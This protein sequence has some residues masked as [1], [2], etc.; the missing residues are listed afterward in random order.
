MKTL[1]TDFI[2][3][4]PELHANVDKAEAALM[5]WET[6]D[7]YRLHEI[8]EKEKVY[9]DAIEFL[10]ESVGESYAGMRDE[11][12]YA[13]DIIE[14]VRE[15]VRVIQKGGTPWDI[16]YFWKNAEDSLLLILLRLRTIESTQ[17][18]VIEAKDEIEDIERNIK[19]YNQMMEREET[20]NL[21]QKRVKALKD[22]LIP[23]RDNN[24][25]LKEAGMRHISEISKLTLLNHVEPEK[26]ILG[27]HTNPD[28]QI[29]SASVTPI[30]DNEPEWL[31]DM[32]NEIREYMDEVEEYLNSPL[33]DYS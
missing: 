21:T 16:Q 22:F 32:L 29:S 31:Y 26:T 20:V 13:D 14:S 25:Y 33:A 2:L 17:N 24:F 11:D 15:F 23:L 19:L 27:K 1:N 30:G 18:F 28:K 9:L 7:W 6:E 10:T 5:F 8:Y 4:M 12:P 3:D